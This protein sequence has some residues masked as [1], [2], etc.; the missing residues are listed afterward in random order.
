M[1]CVSDG[2]NQAVVICCLCLSG[3][4]SVSGDAGPG[5]QRYENHVIFTSSQMAPCS[6]YSVLYFWPGTVG[7]WSKVVY[8]IKNMV[9]FGT[10][11]D[12]G[13]LAPCLCPLQGQVNQE[14]SSVKTLSNRK[15]CC[16]LAMES[17]NSSHCI[18]VLEASLQT[19]WFESRL[20]HKRPWLGVP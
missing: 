14:L 16:L 1:K 13:V 4:S 19:T 12:Q 9:P 8:C 17:M 5:Q 18:S 11:P 20:Y 7:L 2:E 6:L 3:G 15:K 10:Q